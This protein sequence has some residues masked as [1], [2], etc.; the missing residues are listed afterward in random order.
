MEKRNCLPYAARALSFLLI[1]ALLLSVLSVMFR[2][3]DNRKEAGMHYLS[4]HGHLGEPEDSLDVIFLGDSMTY[5]SYSPLEMWE[6]EGFTS[7]VS[8]IGGGRMS[9]AYDLLLEIL[10]HQHP[11]VVVLEAHVAARY[12][13]GN[14]ALLLEASRVFPIFGDH[15]C[16]KTISPKDL[17]AQVHYTYKDDNKGFWPNRSTEAADP[18]G[19]MERTKEKS[20]INQVTRFYLSRFIRLC[21]QQDIRLLIV[22]TPSTKNWNM[23]KH[24]AMQEL[25]DQYGLEFLDLDLLTDE[26]GINWDTDSRDKGDHLNNSGA[27]KVSSYISSYLSKK[28]QLP[29]HREDPA[30]SSWD[31]ALA[32]YQERMAG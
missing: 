24:N 28:Y 30:Y 6:Q 20:S 1:L 7:Y 23:K 5:S 19:Y 31:D 9:N 15:D 22:G 11:K 25:A 21:E 27:Q 3:K 32:A 4:A 2:P 18:E 8:A 26:I 12:T 17:F 13:P 10:K 16:W 14:E 29:D